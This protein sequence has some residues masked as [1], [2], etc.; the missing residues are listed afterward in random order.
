MQAK[1][2]EMKERWHID[3]LRFPITVEGYGVVGALKASVTEQV[4]RHNSR[5]H[6]RFAGYRSPGFMTY[7]NH[8]RYRDFG[9]YSN[10]LL[11]LDVAGTPEHSQA[12]V[13]EA[14]S[15]CVAEQPEA[16]KAAQYKM[17]DAVKKAY[18]NKF[19]K[20][21]AAQGLVAPDNDNEEG[22]DQDF[23]K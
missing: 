8:T 20:Y 11:Y 12:V 1:I 9:L 22:D 5:P 18:I 19:R 21:T 15:S 14:R 17:Y 6:P 16:V 13:A 3:D 10:H 23:D 4:W 2:A 7:Y